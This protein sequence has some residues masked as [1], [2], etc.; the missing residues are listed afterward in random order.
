MSK[1]EHKMHDKFLFCWLWNKWDY[2]VT[3]QIRYELD[4]YIGV[5]HVTI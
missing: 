3:D 4:I 1:V 2:L 5:I